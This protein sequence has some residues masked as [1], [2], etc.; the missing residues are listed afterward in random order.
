[1]HIPLLLLVDGI[2][3]SIAITTISSPLPSAGLQATCG[4]R[5]GSSHSLIMPILHRFRHL[6]RRY[7]PIWRRI[8]DRT[9]PHS[10]RACLGG[11]MC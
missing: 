5:S 1:M 10:T 7:M 4:Y 8:E 11:R 6:Y 9:G 3:R 2:R